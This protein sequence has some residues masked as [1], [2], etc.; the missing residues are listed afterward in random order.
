MGST[1]SQRVYQDPDKPKERILEECKTILN[2][3]S[4]GIYPQRE[5]NV[6]VTIQP[7]IVKILFAEGKGF[8]HRL[9]GCFGTGPPKSTKRD[10]HVLV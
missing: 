8:P 10:S 5:D 9:I 1:L 7:R 2:P 6:Y 3:T 4:N